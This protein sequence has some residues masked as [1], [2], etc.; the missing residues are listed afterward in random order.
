MKENTVNQLEQEFIPPAESLEL[1]NLGFN[2]ETIC[3]FNSFQQIKG[4]ITSSIDG[5][6]IKKDKWDD[7]LPAPTYRQAFKW[8]RDNHNLSGF[9]LPF[10]ENLFDFRIYSTK[11]GEHLYSSPEFP[12][13]EEAELACIRRLIEIVKEQK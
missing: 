8:F 12:S 9:A 3:V 4:A 10:G 11:E 1:F 6:Y 2:L 13:T 5:D 7:R